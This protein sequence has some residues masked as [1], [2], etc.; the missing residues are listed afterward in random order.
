MKA[1]ILSGGKGTRLAPYTMVLPKPLVPIGHKPILDIIVRQ[2][3]YYGFTDITLTLGYLSEIIQAYFYNIDDIHPEIKIKYIRESKP[4][5]TAGSLGII[6]EKIND[7]F[8][9]MNGDILTSLNYKYL[10]NYHCMKKSIL[11]VAT[12]KKQIKIDLGVI[13]S[14]KDDYI[15]NYI[16]KPEKHFDVSMGVYI[17]SPEV[18]NYIN[19][20]DYLD[21]PDLV[22]KLIENGE[23]V[24]CY[25]NDSF[26]MDIG[27]PEDFVQAQEKFEQMKDV[28]LP[29]DFKN[30]E[31]SS[32]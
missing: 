15:S 12:H 3:C 32:V 16:E 11:T 26:W 7:P 29:G 25:Q 9:V 28:F 23:K 27:R 5:G 6:K 17:Y 14:D 10:Y 2:L 19:E 20:N 22:L 8:L 30:V 24:A 21:F 18:L 4:L 13:Q 31:S 1:I